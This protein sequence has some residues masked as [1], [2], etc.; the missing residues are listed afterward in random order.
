MA[1]FFISMVLFCAAPA[2]GKDKYGSTKGRGGM[3]GR[4][5]STRSRTSYVDSESNRKDDYILRS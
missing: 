1:C 5:R 2:L 4:K 3:F